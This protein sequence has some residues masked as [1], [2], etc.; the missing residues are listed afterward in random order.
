MTPTLSQS[1]RNRP[2]G[3]GTRDFDRIYRGPAQRQ[4]SAHFLVV[5]RRTASGHSRWGI[6]VQ[7]RLGTA[8]VRNRVKRRVREILRQAEP[9]LPAGWDVAVQPRTA[10]VARADFG[11]LA[12]EL[13]TLLAVTLRPEEKA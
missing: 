2:R 4:R 13:E 6:S 12:R 8:V 3:L 1:A 10:A 11:A 5:A 7:A 9:Q